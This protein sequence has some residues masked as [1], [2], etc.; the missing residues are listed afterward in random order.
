MGQVGVRARS[1]R[2]E[3]EGGVPDGKR[4]VP[5]HAHSF[6]ASPPGASFH[7]VSR[8]QCRR[9]RGLLRA[10]IRIMRPLARGPCLALTPFCEASLASS[11]WMA[12]VLQCLA[13][14]LSPAEP[15]PC[16]AWRQACGCSDGIMALHVSPPWVVRHPWSA[17]TTGAVERVGH[18]RP[19]RR[20]GSSSV[21]APAFGLDERRRPAGRR[22]PSGGRRGSSSWAAGAVGADDRGC[23]ARRRPLSVWTLGAVELDD[24][25]RRAGRMAPSSRTA[26]AV[27]L[28]GCARRAGRHPWSAWTVRLVERDGTGGRAG[29]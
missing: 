25:A 14:S 3:G 22:G 24:R 27:T 13:A 5:R 19:G 21:T 26:I 4:G 20:R 18:R 16:V 8:G 29:R 2:C 12:H 17:R 6:L 23:R 11:P 15:G 7:A 10:S 9:A 1:R 28:D